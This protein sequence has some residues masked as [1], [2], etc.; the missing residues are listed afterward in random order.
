MCQMKSLIKRFLKRVLH[1]DYIK[2]IIA[3]HYDAKRYVEHSAAFNPTSKS[4]LEARI[5]LQY[6]ILEKGIT[7]PNRHIPFGMKVAK[8]LVVLIQEFEKKYD[9]THQVEHGVAVL[10][11]YLDIHINAGVSKDEFADISQ[12][13]LVHPNIV[14][15]KQLHFSKGDYYAIKNRPFPEFA[16]GRHTIRNY[17]NASV[18]NSKIKD[19][20]TLAMAAPSACNRQHVRVRCIND[21][22]A[23]GRILELQGGNRGFGHMSDKVLVVSAELKEEIGGIRERYDAYVN[24]GIFLMN[25]CYALTYCEVAH[26]ILTGSLERESDAEIRSIAKIPESEVIVSILCCGEA[27][28]EFDVALSPRRDVDE[29]LK[30]IGGR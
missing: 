18:P 26:C 28:E 9:L 27:T 17:S 30:F 1:V 14:A 3:F 2:T 12:F 5:I 21:H 24:G 20:V 22:E 29:V 25:L 4:A 11:E 10:K 19:A 23:C 15:S 16:L 8:D 7:M 13:L 6:H